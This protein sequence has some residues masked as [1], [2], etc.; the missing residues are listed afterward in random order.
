MDKLTRYSDEFINELKESVNLVDLVSDYLE[1]KKSGNRYKGLCPFHSEKTPSFF[2]NPDNNFYHC[3]GCGAGGDAINFVMEIENLTFVE[4]VKMLTERTGM[5]LPDLSNQQRQ[6][7]KEREQLFSLNKLAARFYNYLLTE[8]EMGRDALNYLKERGF[9]E[10]EIEEFKL[11]YAADEWQLL[12][13]F[14][15]K[16]GFGIN[17]INKAG[18]IS[19]GKNNS[20]YDKFRNRVMFP[21][22]NNR[23]EVIAF[24][25]RIL[26]TEDGYGPKYLNSPETQIFS[27]KKNLYGLHLAKETIRKKNSC[28]IMEGYTD[29][30]Q[31][32][33]N[34][35]N[36]S[37][38]S[39]G[40]AFTEEQ[41]KLIHRYAENAYIAYDADT[42]GNKATLRG[43]DILSGTGIN[44]KVIQLAEGSDPDQLLK[45]EGKESF[46]K[47]IEE[48]VNLI[49]FKIN[50]IVKNKNLNDPGVRKKVLKSIV[51][52]LSEVSD[53]LEREIY[54][55][56]AAAKTDFKAEVLADEV[57]KEFQRNKSRNY[58]RNR[59]KQNKQTEKSFDLYSQL[60]YYQKVE[61]EILAH[62]ISNPGLR[63]QITAR[64]SK[65]DFNGRTSQLAERLFRGSVISNS[66]K[67]DKIKNELGD[68]LLS[69]WSEILVKQ[70]NSLT[71]EHILELA[72]Y[73]SSKR[74]ASN[75]KKLCNL[76]SRRE[77]SLN[78]L[79][80]ILL[81][82]YSLNYNIERRD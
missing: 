29:V 57:E 67:I 79:N 75:K 7:Y 5:E 44:V 21:I 48:A 6:R 50:M 22:F 47:L 62:F 58:Q 71:K 77:L 78:K 69:Y 14:L 72:E 49:D 61:E 66:V 64:L 15:Q 35:F 11:G 59:E 80:R 54:I 1:L 63:E 52:L 9:G 4:S 68:E 23:G 8:T 12:L 13:N 36:N 38:A 26:E 43:L 82:F 53:N 74:I 81:T 25:G 73:L 2:V 55:E 24:G 76:L 18:L 40:T 41:A 34:G 10:S 31:A 17:L 16:K 37:I 27:K 39:L 33:K 3:F 60:S 42:A 19:E 46:D 30:I 20:Y 56:R 70:D 65:N 28:I 45:N 32:H 51:K